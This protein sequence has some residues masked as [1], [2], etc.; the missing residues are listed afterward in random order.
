MRGFLRVE[1][2]R[3]AGATASAANKSADVAEKNLIFASRPLIEIQHLSFDDAPD[4]DF[5]RIRFECHNSGKETGIITKIII[6]TSATQA[7]IT[8]SSPLP[9][10]SSAG[11]NFPIEAGGAI[12]I[13]PILTPVL[14]NTPGSGI[15]TGKIS[16]DVIIQ[17]IFDDILGN[18]YN[19]KFPFVFD[20]TQSKFVLNIKFVEAK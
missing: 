2:L 10:V 16:L 6:I 17:V 11:D 15:R 18:H 19:P 8:T 1:S 3:I 9:L 12:P 4:A 7:G 20:H 5:S 13:G 14:S